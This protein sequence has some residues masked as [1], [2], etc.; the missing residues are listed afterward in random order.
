MRLRKI[1]WL[2]CLDSVLTRFGCI[3]RHTRHASGGD[4][5]PILT[6][7]GMSRSS[8]GNSVNSSSD[9]AVPRCQSFTQPERDLTPT[10]SEDSGSSCSGSMPRKQGGKGPM[11]GIHG[12]SMSKHSSQDSIDQHRN[13]LDNVA[14]Y[15]TLRR[16]NSRKQSS[17][18]LDLQPHGGIPSPNTT[19][20]AL[21]SLPSPFSCFR[22]P[23]A[24]IQSGEVQNQLNKEKR[25]SSVP[26]SP[27][28]KTAPAPSNPTNS[29]KKPPAPPKRTMSMKN[30]HSSGSS[31]QDKEDEDEVHEFP[32]PPPPIAFNLEVM[33]ANQPK[34]NGR[35]LDAHSE[36]RPSPLK[37]GL[38]LQN[39]TESNLAARRRAGSAE[40]EANANKNNN[41]V[42]EQGN[43]TPTDQNQNDI[44][45]RQRERSN[46]ATPR[47][48]VESIPFA[49]DNAGTIKQKA[50]QPKLSINNFDYLEA[51]V[52]QALESED[53]NEP[54]FDTVKRMPKT[55]K[56]LCFLS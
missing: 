17:Q 25:S 38:K 14:Q 40:K 15:A 26:S 22:S 18:S 5:V 37:D 23:Y 44:S 4:V 13:S 21:G 1:N 56:Q 29:S 51:D 52:D 39:V 31:N 20:P 8:S 6:K 9:Y 10:S 49:N 45:M 34:T 33:K 55:G 42:A 46:S 50:N 41:N 19:S 43:V 53:N 30:R 54:D 12:L 24:Q 16:T 36:R 2:I 28:S 7:T 47:N 11:K 35:A 27:V 32:P 3:C 48:S